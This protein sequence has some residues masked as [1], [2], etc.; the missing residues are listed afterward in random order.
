M[1]NYFRIELLKKYLIESNVFV[2]LW[3]KLI[4]HSIPFK[5]QSEMNGIESGYEK[6]F[7][8]SCEDVTLN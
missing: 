6:V 3:Q 8:L 4:T 7:L 5:S 2:F 1:P